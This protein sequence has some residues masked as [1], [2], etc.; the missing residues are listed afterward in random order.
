MNDAVYVQPLTESECSIKAVTLN[1]HRA[2][3]QRGRGKKWGGGG[4]MSVGQVA[5]CF[6]L[7]HF[8][9]AFTFLNLDELGQPW[10]GGSVATG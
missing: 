2:W 3:G 7:P 8:G 6:L 5:V 1:N 4:R 10:Q 9:H